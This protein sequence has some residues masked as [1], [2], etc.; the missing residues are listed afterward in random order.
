M[1]SKRAR[2][3]SSRRGG[4]AL[5]V[6]ENARPWNDEERE[7]LLAEVETLRD[8]QVEV[9]HSQHLYA[10]LF[11]LAPVGYVNL[12]ARGVILAAN[13]AAAEILGFAP[14]ILNGRHFQTYVATDDL[15]DFAGH[16]RRC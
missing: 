14:R 13:L 10:E 16:L 6:P 2:G 4:R 11:E 8:A 9:E 1:K 3:S 5:A 12:S 7:Q 15:A